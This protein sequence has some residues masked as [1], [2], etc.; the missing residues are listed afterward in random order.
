MPPQAKDT[1]SSKYMPPHLRVKS[2]WFGGSKNKR[3]E[4]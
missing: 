4:M 2:T 3:R 1:R